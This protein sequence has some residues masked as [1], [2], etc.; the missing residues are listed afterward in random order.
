MCI[1]DRLCND[2]SM[3]CVNKFIELLRCASTICILFVFGRIVVPII[4]IRPNIKICYSVQPY[5]LSRPVVGRS[6]RKF[7]VR[8]LPP[9]LQSW[10]TAF[11]SAVY[12]FAGPLVRKS[13]VCILP[14]ASNLDNSAPYQGYTAP[15]SYT[16][17]TLPTNREV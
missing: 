16:H 14:P 17:L 15:V 12:P 3:S 8:N 9:G 2:A 10:S 13:A 1:R 4:L 6:V 5:F 11:W 7:V